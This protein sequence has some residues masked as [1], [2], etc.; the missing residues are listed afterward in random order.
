MGNKALRRP[1]PGYSWTV[2]H[3]WVIPFGYSAAS[4]LVSLG[5]SVVVSLVSGGLRASQAGR[6]AWL[7]GVG[8]GLGAVF[9]AASVTMQRGGDRMRRRNGTAYLVRE[10]ARGWAADDPRDFDTQVRRHFA[11]VAEVPGPGTIDPGT[12][13]WPLDGDARQWDAKVTELARSFRV[14]ELAFRGEGPAGIFITAW[15]AVAL[16]FGMRA[17]AADR[18]LE[19]HVWQ[20]PSNG[21]SGRVRPEIWSQTPHCVGAPV[22]ATGLTPA[23]FQWDA[24]LTIRA[25]PKDAALPESGA[26]VSVLLVRFSKL[27]WGPVPGAGAEGGGRRLRLQVEDPAGVV[28]VAG[29][30]LVRIHELRCTPAG[31]AEQF[32]WNQYPFL[33]ASAVEWVQQTGAELAGHTL[34]LGALMPNEIALEI[35]ISAGRQSCTGWPRCLWPIVF[36]K[37]PKPELVI[38]RLSLGTAALGE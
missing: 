36:S 7:M 33:A 12:W 24:D 16:A 37:F 18:G 6:L 1:H 26:P 20:R 4:V 5:L 23:V 38:P 32:D 10:R 14:L 19:L 22:P 13:D 29:T 17:A 8:F 2:R 21:R 9:L 11:R 30:I 15:W 28:P 35:G 27:S 34:L 31:D 3:R 25:R